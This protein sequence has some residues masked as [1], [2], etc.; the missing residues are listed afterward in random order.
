[1]PYRQS[2]CNAVACL[3][4]GIPPIRL[5]SGAPLTLTAR[6]FIALESY[7]QRTRTPVIGTRHLESD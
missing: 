7:L 1:M 4:R 3:K 5:R 2:I 6:A